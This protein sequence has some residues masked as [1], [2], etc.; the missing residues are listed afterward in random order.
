MK[1]TTASLSAILISGLFLGIGCAQQPPPPPPANAAPPPPAVSQQG[2][3]KAFNVGLNG[4]TNGFILA[5]GTTVMVP[6]EC[7]A[8]LLSTV[9]E[10]SRIAFTGV[11]TPGASGRPLVRAQSITANGQ[12]IAISPIPPPGR[13]RRPLQSPP[14]PPPPADN[15]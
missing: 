2:R 6:P 8:Q 10:G 7:A 14:P 9:K 15:D 4:E 1:R 11:S 3:I 12:T 5:D 13:P